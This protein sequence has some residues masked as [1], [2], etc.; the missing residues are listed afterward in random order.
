MADGPVDLVAARGRVGGN[1]ALLEELAGIFAAE[2]PAR[3]A[4]LR[5]AVAARDPRVIERLAHTLKGSAGIVG[6]LEVQRLGLAL[7]ELAR[8]RRLESADATLARLESELDRVVA[9][10]TDGAW[11]AP[12]D[13]A[14]G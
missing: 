6:A 14:G 2:A 3:L 5:A 11:A 12:P 4:E 1:R 8:G 10:F 9:F 13:G 7:E